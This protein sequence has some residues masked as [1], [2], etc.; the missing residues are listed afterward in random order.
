MGLC[1]RIP[2]NDPPPGARMQHAVTLVLWFR[3]ASLRSLN[4]SKDSRR[5]R[6]AAPTMGGAGRGEEVRD[7]HDLEVPSAFMEWHPTAHR[8]PLPVRDAVQRPAVAA[9]GEHD[10]RRPG[11]AHPP[12]R[13]HAGG[14]HRSSRADAAIAAA[15]LRLLAESGYEALSMEGVAAAAGVAKSTL[16]RRY[17][18]KAELVV[19]TL[20]AMPELRRL[21]EL[22]Q[23]R[24]TEPTRDALRDLL[25][26]GAVIMA[27]PGAIEALSALQ[28]TGTRDA[29]LAS[30]MRGRVVGPQVEL[31]TRRI[32]EGIRRGEIRA[33]AP[34]DAAIDAAWGAMFAR[35]SRGLPLD[36]TWLDDLVAVICDGIAAR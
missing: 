11:P 33:D 12:L 30:G 36:D 24:G 3:Y 21:M 19:A 22:L 15:T 10:P 9:A 28:A 23:K 7:R 34:V 25:R 26:S 14:R 29:E 4:V 5:P 18:S 17:A 1:A 6:P 35:T 20:G 8:H 27:T 32:A 31:I 2:P 16:Y 13:P